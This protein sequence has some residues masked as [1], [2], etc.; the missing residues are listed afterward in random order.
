MAN[1]LE[2][3]FQMTYGVLR[4]RSRVWI[5]Q[6]DELRQEILAQIYNTLYTIHRKM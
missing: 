2:V 5:S 1:G 6:D 4:F 3:D